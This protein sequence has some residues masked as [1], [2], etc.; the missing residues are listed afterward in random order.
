MSN[1]YCYDLYQPKRKVDVSKHDEYLRNNLGICP[2]ILADNL[3]VTERF[4][5]SRQRKLGV[6][7]LTGNPKKGERHVER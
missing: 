7:P 1:V 4:V 6:R 5:I 3:G 2:A